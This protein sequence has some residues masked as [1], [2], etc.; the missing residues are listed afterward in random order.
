VVAVVERLRALPLFAF[1]SVDELF[2]IAATGRR[3]VARPD[4]VLATAGERSASVRLLLEGTATAGGRD[5]AVTAPATLVFEAVLAG[6]PPTRTLRAVEACACLDLDRDAF[7]VM[8]SDSIELAQGLFRTLL[9]NSERLRRRVGV[10]RKRPAAVP[11]GPLKPIDVVLALR[12]S[13]W[14]AGAAVDQVVALGAVARDVPLTAGQVLFGAHERPAIHHVLE[15]EVRLEGGGT[16]PV[17][18]RPGDAIGVGETLAGHA[19]GRRAV[20]AAGGRALR[21]DGD[22]LCEVLDEHPGLLESVFRGVLR[23]ADEA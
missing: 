19:F 2:R 1:V 14:L 15:G 12:R 6:R 5:G 3:A 21:I 20:A 22:R 9:G 13:A 18:G 11:Q 23:A 16:A 17:V 8:L 10:A 4:D 7:L